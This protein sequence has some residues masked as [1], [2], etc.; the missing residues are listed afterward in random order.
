MSVYSREPRYDTNEAPKTATAAERVQYALQQIEGAQYLLSAA[1]A[2]LCPVIGFVKEWEKTG[3]LMDQVQ[4]LWH[5]V[6]RFDR[7]KLKLDGQ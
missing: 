3:K 1:C 7:S 5:R 6:N 4:A 2:N